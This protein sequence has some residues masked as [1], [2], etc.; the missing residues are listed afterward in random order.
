[1]PENFEMFRY[2]DHLRVRW[3][4]IAVACGAAAAIALIAAFFTPNRY[5]STARV[6]IE[7]PAGSDPRGAMAVSPIYLESLKSYELVASGDRLFLDAIDHFKLPRTGSIERLKRSVLKVTIPRNT[8]V[9]EIS[10]TLDEP[11]QAQ[12]L[13]LYIA[14]QTVKLARNVSADT[15][16]D[17]LADAEKQLDEAQ[18][19]FNAFGS[20]S[21]SAA[22]P[23]DT[24]AR[25]AQ[26]DAAR[27]AVYAAVEHLAQVRSMAGARGE[28]LRIVDPGV[29]P[30][31][32]SWP[33]VPLMLLVAILVALVVSLL[34]VTVEFNYRLER[35]AAPRTVAPLA[36][37]KTRND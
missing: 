20:G 37:V 32:P 5:T 1:M 6:L 28:R 12:A 11:A 8:R 15:E 18:A 19:R 29:I 35:P 2:L 26:R 16:R 34:Y 21:G 30:Q 23:A 24:D 13:A 25:G 9:L 36:R 14:E 31:R 17:L 7:P 10:A 4:V 27:G 22:S 33:N 3:R